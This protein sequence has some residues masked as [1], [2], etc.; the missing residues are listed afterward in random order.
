MWISNTAVALLACSRS[1]S[2]QSVSLVRNQT[3]HF[4]LHWYWPLLT[5]AVCG[6]MATLVGTPSNGDFCRFH[7]GRLM[8]VPRSFPRRMADRRVPVAAVLLIP[9]VDHS[10]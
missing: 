9:G 1:P 3:I 4:A 5:A 7:A 10:H 6:G 8:G 2:P